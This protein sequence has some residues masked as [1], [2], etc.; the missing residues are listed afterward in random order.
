MSGR[1]K[2]LIVKA[3]SDMYAFPFLLGKAAK[4]KVG[5][6]T[7]FSYDR[8]FGSFPFIIQ[9]HY[10]LQQ[11]STNIHFFA[12]PLSIEVPHP[13]S[14]KIIDNTYENKVSKV[15]KCITGQDIC[16]NNV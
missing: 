6:A 15:Y 10:R 4:A 16:I 2:Q 3:C 9:K 12:I 8:R 11:T 7:F 5:S 14:V 1:F 13:K